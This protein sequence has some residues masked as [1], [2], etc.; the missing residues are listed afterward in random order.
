MLKVQRSS[1][2]HVVFKV[3]GRINAEQISALMD[4]L[5]S[6]T[7]SRRIVM[8]LKDVTLVDRDAVSFL[9]GCVTGGIELTNCPAYIREWITKEPQRS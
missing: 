4:L 9:K 1:N 3:S 6:E 2:G 8:D 5:K 7:A